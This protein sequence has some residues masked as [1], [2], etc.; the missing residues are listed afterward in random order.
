M[1]PKKGHK[2]GPKTENCSRKLVSHF[3]KKSYMRLF[4]GIEYRIEKKY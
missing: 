2:N 3:A 1:H 4:L